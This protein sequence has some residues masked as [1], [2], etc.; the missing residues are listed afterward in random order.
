MDDGESAFHII[1]FIVLLFI[2]AVLE[3]F[4]KAIHLMNEKEIERKAEEENDKRSLLLRNVITR[5]TIYINSIQLI[6]TL[7]DLVMGC[8]FLPRWVM[9]FANWLS[10]LS[11]MSGISDALTSWIALIIATFCLMYILLTFGILFPKKLAQRYP[12]AWAYCFIRYIHFLRTVLYPLTGFVAVSANAFLRLIGFRSSDEQ[13]EVTE[14]EIISMVNEGHELGVLEAG[15]VEMIT[16]IFEFGDKEASDIMTHRNNITAIDSQTPFKEA[17]NFMLRESNSRYPVFEE[18]LDHIVG[19]LY[20]KDAMRF[21]TSDESL[22]QSVGSVEGLIREAVFVPET[23]NIDD[24]FRSMQSEKNQMVIVMDEY[25]QTAGLV[26]M[27]DILEEIVG[28]I[29]DEY[30]PEENHIEEKGENEYI[31]EGMTK[32]EDL[33]ERFDMDFGETEFETLNGFMISKLDRIPEEGEDTE[34][35]IDGYRFK[36]LKVEKNVIQSVLVTKVPDEETLSETP[37]EES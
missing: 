29:M 21:H 22:N 14:E 4:H 37:E 26:T 3:G 34:L 25:G 9:F 11:F 20:L 1:L 8:F 15:E 33:K 31:I 5:A 36:I 7:V 10:G 18:N 13:N 17:L 27:E 32:L 19:V 35:Q 6:V 23:K 28:N 2:M 30:D 16:N 12:D 24:L